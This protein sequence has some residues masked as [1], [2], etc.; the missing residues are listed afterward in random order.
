TEAG[1]QD[2]LDMKAAYRQRRD[3]VYEQMTSLGFQVAK[4]DGA[5]YI[6]AKIPAGYLQDDFEF[7]R[8]LA[9]K[10]G[11]ALIPGSSFGP[12]GE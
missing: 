2:T 9:N 3:F 7:A 6:F 1:R 4:P 11:L 10:N 12:G 5:F 8:D